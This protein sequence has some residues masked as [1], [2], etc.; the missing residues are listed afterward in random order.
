MK[1]VRTEK[2]DEKYLFAAAPVNQAVLTMAM[3]AIFSQI[4][5]LIYNMAD[6][7]YLGQTENAFMVAG[8]SLIL[9]V[10]NITLALAGLTGVGGG[11]LISRLLGANKDEEARKVCSFCFWLS[12]LISLLFSLGLFLFREPL[13][14]FLGAS[15]N[16]FAYASQYLISVLV[17]GGLPTVLSNVL[18]NLVRS[19]GLS[20]KA[21]FG[22]S[23]GGLLNIIL[24][25]LFMFVLLPAGYE[26]LGVGIATLVSNA[27]ALGYFLF[28]IYQE[29][30]R[31]VLTIDLKKSRPGWRNVFSIFTVGIPSS[32]TALLF[33]VDYAL[34]GRLMASY[35][36]YALAAI[37]VVLKVERLPLNIGIGI[38]QGMLPIIAFN[39]SAGNIRRLLNTICF[40]LIFG[41]LAAAIS[42]LF[43]ELFAPYLV[44]VFI[45]HEQTLFFGTSF[46]RVRSLATPLMFISFFVL[47]IFQGL[48]KGGIALFLGV[49]RWA[50]LNIPIL[51]AMDTVFGMMGIVWAQVVGDILTVAL[52]LA[53]FW[54]YSSHHLKGKKDEDYG[55][56]P[57][58]RGQA[59]LP[60]PAAGK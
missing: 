29:K 32:V 56:D 59:G 52:S 45:R 8:V 18:A 15:E 33:D 55:T 47:Y 39:Y 13:L 57:G 2:P 54:W 37:G 12:L 11:A 3:P 23:M 60:Y 22:I 19:V 31:T 10:F 21:G 28:V 1:R 38:C 25:P 7:F 44:E 6:T 42:V 43:Y 26:V 16:T 53:V 46:L 17:T 9:P 48:N 30:E 34:I 35:G 49:T 14:W 58:V 5:V 27:F 50:V 24:D 41:L 51:L 4:I 40:S 36:D 20:S